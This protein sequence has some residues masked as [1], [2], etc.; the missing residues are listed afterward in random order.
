[1]GSTG[2][3][4]PQRERIEEV[5]VPRWD[6]KRRVWWAIELLER[7]R[8]TP[9]RQPA[10]TH[11]LWEVPAEKPNQEASTTAPRSRGTS[12]WREPKA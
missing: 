3:S 11:S 4:E 1:M 8:R 2:D 12:A 5:R 7:E 9:S 10:P 6:A